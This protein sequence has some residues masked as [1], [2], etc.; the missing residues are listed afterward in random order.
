M[1]SAELSLD[2]DHIVVG[3]GINGAWT[4]LHL[5]KRGAKTLILEQVN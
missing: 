1:S 2:F 3:A 4:A 5:A